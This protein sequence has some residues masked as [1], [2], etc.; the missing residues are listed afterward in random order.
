MLHV[1]R[2]G[3]RDRGISLKVAYFKPVSS[4]NYETR[5]KYNANEFTCIRQFAYSPNNNKTIDMVLSVNGIP[6]IALELKINIL[7]NL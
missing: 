3:I 7:G 2:N 1:L 4:L 5:Q 6:L